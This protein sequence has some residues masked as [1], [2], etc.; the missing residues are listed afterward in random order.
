MGTLVKPSKNI[1]VTL[2]HK[3]SHKGHFFDIKIYTSS[4]SWINKLPLMYGLLVCSSG[5][6]GCKKSKYWEKII[7]KVVQMK[8]LTMHIINQ[9][10]SF[11]TF[12]VENL[13][14]IFMEHDLY[15]KPLNCHPPPPPICEHICESALSKLK[16]L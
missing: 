11:D 10:L 3:T 15:L 13:Q 2:E 5:I 14:N 9:K 4:E 16:L 8:F 6:W 1:F 12:T 7:F